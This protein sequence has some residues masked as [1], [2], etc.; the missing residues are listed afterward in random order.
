MRQRI[1]AATSQNRRFKDFDQTMMKKKK[2]KSL[3]Q[4]ETSLPHSQMSMLPLKRATGVYQT[5]VV[6][7]SHNFDPLGKQ[8]YPINPPS[9]PQTAKS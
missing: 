9:K 3:R 8:F 7:K 6:V 1:S 4:I 5:A 2:L